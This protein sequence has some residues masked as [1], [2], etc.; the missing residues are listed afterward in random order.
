M[1]CYQ[2]YYLK[3][4]IIGVALNDWL[5]YRLGDSV[6]DERLLW[7]GIWDMRCTGEQGRLV[8]NATSFKLC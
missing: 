4:I 1:V 8:N 7:L 2:V 6:M 5:S 3:D